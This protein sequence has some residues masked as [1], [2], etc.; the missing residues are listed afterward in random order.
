MSPVAAT[1]AAKIRQQR[2]RLAKKP[3]PQLSQIDLRC[4]IHECGHLFACL[5]YGFQIDR[6]TLSARNVVENVS[7]PGRISAVYDFAKPMECAAVAFAGEV[8]EQMTFGD[9]LSSLGSEDW[10]LFR[11]AMRY[12]TSPTHRECEAIARMMAADVVRTNLAAI[13]QVAGVLLARGELTGAD[14]R[15]LISVEAS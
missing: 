13:R 8:A 9:T 4:A 12:V 6:V 10:N 15:R 7:G 3:V 1:I 14:I 2:Q 11:R 5:C